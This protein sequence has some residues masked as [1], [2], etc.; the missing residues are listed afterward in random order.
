MRKNKTKIKRNTSL[1]AMAVILGLTGCGTAGGG[2]TDT[3]NKDKPLVWW[4][5]QPSDSATGELDIAAVNFNKD[6]YYVGFDMRQGASLQGQ[7]VE[8]YLLASDLSLDRNGDGTIG[9][10]LAIG[11]S[12]HNI[13]AARTRGVRS[14]LG[15]GIGEGDD[16]NAAP[17][18]GDL[19][20]DGNATEVKDAQVTLDGKTLIV[21]ELASREM[22]TDK[23]ATWDANAAGNAIKEW[24]SAFGDQIDLIVSNN[25]GMGMAMF[26]AWAHA[27]KV[28]VFGY[29][30]N[31]DCVAATRDGFCGSISQHPD[32]QAYLTLRVI[33]NCLDGVD[34]QTGIGIPD[35]AGNVLSDS[36][37]YYKEEERA[38][39][40]LNVA[41]TAGNYKD[42]LDP[43][44][45]Y[46][47]V[48]HQLSTK[49][50]PERRVFLSIYNKDDDFLS[51]T[52]QP[53]LQQYASLL[54]LDVSFVGGNGH[55]ESTIL[56]SLDV[57]KFDAYAINMVKT[58]NAG[59]Y[60]SLLK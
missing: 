48:S 41:V 21:R 35:E 40:A 2:T 51:Q 33:R 1:I 50:H 27:N 45:V 60:T 31:G 57:N 37:F 4:N 25:D 54:N 19:N 12:G 46:A 36:D 6:T 14:A 28:P 8:D 18:K 10:V 17:I 23:G 34:V 16:L 3:A 52:Y 30:A 32:V 7:M 29:D 55:D 49:D 15:T 39:Y 20:L 53:L 26:N 58:D 43:K 42:F 11:D 22:I 24:S 56:K 38:F 47:P 59:E 13:S 5:R 44:A 9:Y